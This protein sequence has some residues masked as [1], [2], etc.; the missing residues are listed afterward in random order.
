M[1]DFKEYKRDKQEYWACSTPILFVESTKTCYPMTTN[2]KHITEEVNRENEFDRTNVYI[3][4]NFV[5]ILEITMPP[6]Y[7][8]L[9]SLES[10]TE[11]V[12]SYRIFE[13]DPAHME[14]GKPVGKMEERYHL[15]KVNAFLRRGDIAAVDDIT[16]RFYV[17]ECMKNSFSF[18]DEYQKKTFLNMAVTI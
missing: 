7:P 1:T 3:K 4:D 9:L 17:S 11:I 5:N 15:Y 12:L 13:G 10:G 14:D 16:Y 18:D 2:F 8:E 6:F